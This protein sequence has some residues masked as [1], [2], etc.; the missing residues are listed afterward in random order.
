MDLETFRGNL[1]GCTASGLSKVLQRDANSQQCLSLNLPEKLTHLIT[2]HRLPVPLLKVR[3]LC[4][5]PAKVEAMWSLPLGSHGFQ[6][7]VCPG[8]L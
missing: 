7:K 2:G 1:Q 3:C 8:Y 4:T 6:I 5:T